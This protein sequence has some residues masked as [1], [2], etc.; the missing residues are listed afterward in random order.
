MQ[1]GVGGEPGRDG[2]PKGYGLELRCLIV[3]SF[4]FWLGRERTAEDRMTGGIDH[5]ERISKA[6]FVDA[7]TN[8]LSSSTGD[9]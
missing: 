3:L 5:V 9:L 8:C 6:S 1:E 7:K 2:L 4:S